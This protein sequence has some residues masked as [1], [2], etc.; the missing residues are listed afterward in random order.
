MEISEI[1]QTDIDLCIADQI[2]KAH[3]GSIDVIS[4]FDQT[5]FTCGLP[6]QVS[7]ADV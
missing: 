7:V 2:A 6:H 3:G 5:I 4:N 1:F